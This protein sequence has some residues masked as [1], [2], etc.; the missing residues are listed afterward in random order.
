MWYVIGGGALNIDPSKMDAIMKWLVHANVYE[1]KS[2][3][4][5]V[6]YLRKSIASFSVVAAP[7]HAI[8]T[9]AMVSSGEKVSI[10][11]SRS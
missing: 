4:G 9:S 11:L 8:T 7:L 5:A 10:G 3:I 1:V 2:F 6:Q